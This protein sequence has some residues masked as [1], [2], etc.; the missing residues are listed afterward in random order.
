M[1]SQHNPLLPLL[2]CVLALT[3][4]LTG[5]LS[6]SAPA[7]AAP[8]FGSGPEFLPVD[9]AFRIGAS[10]ERAPQQVF[11]Q[12][13]PGYYLYRHRLAFEVRDA[14]GASLGAAGE[15][16]ARIPA[17]LAK[18]DE[19]F[20]DVE[21]YYDSLDV[22][23]TLPDALPEGAVLQVAYQGCADAGLCYPPERRYVA[24]T[25]GDAGTISAVLVERTAA[26]IP[27]ADGN[28]AVIT[29]EG[30]VDLPRT[31][32]TEE[33][34]LAALLG[35]DALLPALLIFFLAGI[36]L[37]FTP[38]V[39]PMVPILSSIIA[40]EKNATRMRAA[41]L[42][43]TYVLA[44][45]LTYALLGLLVGFFGGA[46]NL[47]GWLQSAPVLIVFALLFVVLSLSMFGYYELQLPAFLRERLEGGGSG[48]RLGGVAAMGVFSSLLVSPCV[49]APLAGALVYISTTGD[50]VLGGSALFALALGMGVPLMIVGIGGGTLLPRAGA[51]MNAV[52]AAFGVLLLGVAVWLL[53]RVIPASATLLLWAALAVGSGVALGALDFSPRRGIGNVWKASGAML[54][55]YGVLLIIGAASGGADPLKPL[56]PLTAGAGGGG[57]AEEAPFRPVDDLPQVQAALASAR[58]SGRPVMLDLYADWCISCKIME[59]NVFPEPEVQRLLAQFDLLRADVTDNAPRHRDLLAHYGLFGPPSL[60]FFAPDTGE[61]RS[62]RLQGEIGAAD[63]ARHLES[64]LSAAA[65]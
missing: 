60:L 28:A 1:P 34:R 23:L 31:P 36:G 30:A 37:A 21:V 48:G 12:M 25:G 22:P 17:G 45:A 33:G 40:G 9:E 50:A 18:T 59:R 55:V 56:A 26:A 57:H 46:L 42:S 49:S 35:G 43:G 2:L 65:G 61:L 15:V 4:A 29:A 16:D 3:G 8:G 27:S 20:G 51:W 53:E 64:V 5:A 11:W 54:F 13:E 19:Y 6:V 10:L 62:W 14:N 38:C 52:K 63:F 58:D 24:L 44:M 7:Q 41:V 47:H 32:V 39:L